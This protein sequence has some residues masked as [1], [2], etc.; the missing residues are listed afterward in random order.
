MNKKLTLAGACLWLFAGVLSADEG[1]WMPRQIPD[2]A[3]EL[4]AAGMKLDPAKLADLTGD[5]MGAVV[6]LG[7]CT[8]SFV[9][10]QGLIV[11]NHHCVYGSMQ[12]NSTPER[13]LIAN[14]FLAAELAEE[15]PAA[16][17]T[18][19]Y[20]TTGIRDVTKEVLGEPGGE[21]PR[22][23]LR[24]PGRAPQPHAGRRLREAGRAALQRRAVLRG[25]AL[26]RGHPDGD[27]RRAARLRAGRRD[28]QLRR[29]DRQLDVAAPHRRLRLPARLRRPG[30]QARRL[31]QGERPLSSAALHEDGDRR[32]EGGRL[33]LDRRLPGT[34]LPLSHS[35]R[36]RDGARVLP[37]AVGEVVE[38]P[39]RHPGDG[40]PARHRGRARQLRARSRHG[41]RHEEVR[42]AAP[43]DA[44]RRGRGAARGAGGRCSRSSRPVP[45]SSPL[46]DAARAER[47]APQD[48]AARHGARLAR[49]LLADARP[50]DDDLADVRGA[51]EGR[52]RPRGRLPRPRSQPLPPGGRARPALDR[53]G[54]RPRDA[55]LRPAAGGGAAGRPA[56]RGARRRARGDRQG[57]RRGADRGVP[58]QALRRDEDGR[59]R[60]AQGDGRAVLRRPRAARRQHAR[61]GA[62][63]WRRSPR[64]AA[65]PTGPSRARRCAFVRTT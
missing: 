2:L 29:R 42:R 55:A 53:T 22:R 59:S 51:A 57:R 7:G 43:R 38:G 49:P 20:V 64:S 50:G 1:M 37:A 47:R 25:L 6:S 46:A 8:A 12:F 33:R 63:R 60:G 15:L 31:R 23:R 30:R 48:R 3:P 45:D 34:H 16:P 11:T 62:R 19:V 28:R 9:S 14:G 21:A 54:E 32:G 10:P 13:D 27:P 4:K 39:D 41:E 36:G 18:Y 35:R 24:A 5:P 61:P 52:P 65:R 58:R 40:E 56:H 44:R 17:G 26:P